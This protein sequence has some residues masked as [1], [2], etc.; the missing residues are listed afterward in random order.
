MAYEI[1]CRLEAAG[2]QVSVLALLDSWCP[3]NVDPSEHHAAPFAAGAAVEHS[4]TSRVRSLIFKIKFRHRQF[5]TLSSAERHGQLGRMFKGIYESFAIPMRRKTKAVLYRFCLRFNLPM[6]KL[7]LDP[8]V[9]TYE[10]LRQYRVQP[11]HGNITLVRPGDQS[12]PPN[13]DPYCGWRALT[14]GEITTTFIPGDRSTM[15]LMPHLE[16]LAEF[17]NG[18]MAR[19]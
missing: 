12:V 15:F 8:S 10:W 19:P 7:M 5:S 2:D 6:P 4:L 18:L 17:L 16:K 11:Y 14:D 1:A 9:V 13:S 3:Y